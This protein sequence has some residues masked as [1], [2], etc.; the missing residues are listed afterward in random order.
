MKKIFASQKK[1]HE[2]KTPYDYFRTS[3]VMQKYFS[4]AGMDIHD[5]INYR[6]MY[7]TPKVKIY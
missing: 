7:L 4:G 2:Y 6:S 5:K 1:F 3:N